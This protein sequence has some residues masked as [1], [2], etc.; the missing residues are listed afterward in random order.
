MQGSEEPHT[1]QQIVIF[2]RQM[3]AVH[4]FRQSDSNYEIPFSDYE[5]KTNEVSRIQRHIMQPVCKNVSPLI[6]PIE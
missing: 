4:N 5:Q 3:H 2:D 1:K 6:S